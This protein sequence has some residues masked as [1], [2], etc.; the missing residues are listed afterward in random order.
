[1]HGGG[2][3]IKI[4]R[5]SAFLHYLACGHASQERVGGLGAWGKEPTVICESKTKYVLSELRR[6]RGPW[7]LRSC[8]E[9]HGEAVP[10]SQIEMG[11]TQLLLCGAYRTFL[12]R[13]TI[14]LSA[15]CLDSRCPESSRRRSG[16]HSVCYVVIESSKLRL[17]KFLFC[18]VLPPTFGSTGPHEDPRRSAS[19]QAFSAERIL[20][21]IFP[22]NPCIPWG[23]RSAGRDFY[24]AG[25]LAVVIP[26]RGLTPV[27][28]SV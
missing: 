16:L 25:G 15:I 3:V 19:F 20:M 22:S 5:G 18:S 14:T 24:T 9:V 8:V 11:V 10:K 21:L 7:V 13:P 1:M 6:G 2:A 17:G 26:S 27:L 4:S 12:T 28:P 23:H